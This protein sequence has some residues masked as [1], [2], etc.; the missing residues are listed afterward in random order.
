[1]FRVDLQAIRDAIS[2]SFNTVDMIKLFGDQNA[3]DLEK[4]LLDL[5]ENFKLKKITPDEYETKKVRMPS[6][7]PW[8]ALFH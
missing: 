4:Q 5:E 8:E 3:S 7:A 2:S 1:M 6:C